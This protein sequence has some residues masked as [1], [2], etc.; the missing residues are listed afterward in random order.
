MSLFSSPIFKTKLI[1]PKLAKQNL[2]NFITKTIRQSGVTE[3]KPFTRLC[4][5]SSIPIS[6]TFQGFHELYNYVT[7]HLEKPDFYIKE[8]WQENYL[9]YYKTSRRTYS[10]AIISASGVHV[11]FPYP[12]HRWQ[13][14]VFIEALREN[15]KCLSEPR[16]L[17]A[18]ETIPFLKKEKMADGILL[19]MPYHNNYYHWLV[20][21][22]PR[23]KMIEDDDNFKDLPIIMPKNRTPNFIHDSLKRA[24]FLEQTVFLD[25]GVYRFDKLQIP[26]LLSPPCNPS[27]VAI[28]W[29]RKKLLTATGVSQK[30][31]IYVSR[32]DAVDRYVSNESEVEEVLAEFGFDTVCLSN[33]SLAEKI[34]IFQAAEI[35]IGSHGAG[36]SNLVFT[37]S[38]SV[39][40]EFFQEEG[41][42]TPAFYQIARIRKL[43][44]GFL[45][46]KK[47]GAG[48]YVDVNML[49]ELVERAITNI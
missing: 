26:T 13:G 10:G 19:A 45:V 17:V 38:E 47:D 36:F 35:V 31:R 5:A 15:T 46:C 1:N 27:P 43:K 20:E 12:I 2:N 7:P 29:L 37:P 48:Q 21:M 49:R 9:Q 40:I 41:V 30:K 6:E 34:Q 3:N 39:F 18:L 42:F 24:G 23:L 11:S 33:Y 25:D 22:L 32:R 16:Y 8:D 44:Y 4:R 28:E 14:K